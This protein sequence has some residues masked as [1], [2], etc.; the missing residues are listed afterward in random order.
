MIPATFEYLRPRTIEETVG[1]L[2]K[3]GEDARLLAGGHSLLPAMK[4]RLAQP[5]VLVDLGRISDLRAIREEGGRIAIGA[6][7]T[8]YDIES[9]ELLSRVCPLMPEVASRIGDLQV[10]N[11][12]TIG[13]SLAHADPAADWPAAIL[14]LGA[15]LEAVGPGGRRVMAAKDFFQDLFRTALRPGEVLVSIRVPVTGKTVAYEKFAQKASG[16]AICGVAAVIEQKE[17]RVAITGVAP[18]AYRARAVESVLRGRLSAAVIP[19][20]AGKAAQGVEPLLGHPRLGGI[21]GPSGA[22]P[23][24]PRAGAGAGPRMMP[25]A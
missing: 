24:P 6:M 12:G 25:A 18:K 17:A 19:A 15:E 9:S 1:L 5:K 11:R 4:L 16:F 3:H 20:A 8:H 7:A 21:P 10:R 2:A 14:A 22:G 23:H 13:G